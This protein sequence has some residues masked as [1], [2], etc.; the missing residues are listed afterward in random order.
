MLTCFFD[1]SAI[2]VLVVDEV[3]SHPVRG[4]REIEE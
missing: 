3:S 1:T 4:I 2:V